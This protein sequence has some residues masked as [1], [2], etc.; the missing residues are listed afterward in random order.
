MCIC[1]HVKHTALVRVHLFRKE[2]PLLTV[3]QTHLQWY[4]AEIPPE[5]SVGLLTLLCKGKMSNMR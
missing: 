1:K 4:E 5:K 3:M 2:S